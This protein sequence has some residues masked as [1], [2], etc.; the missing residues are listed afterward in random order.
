MAQLTMAGIAPTL[1]RFVAQGP[2]EESRHERARSAVVRLLKSVTPCRRAVPRPR[3]RGTRPGDPLS[4][5][6]GTFVAFVLPLYFGLKTILY[7][8]SLIRTYAV[9]EVTSDLVFFGVLAFLTIAAPRFA[10]LTFCIAYGGFSLVAF[11]YIRRSASTAVVQPPDWSM[12]RFAALAMVATYASANQAYAV[13]LLT[14]VLSTSSAAG[15]S[16]RSSC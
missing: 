11:A 1:M 8:L 10:I 2:T 12:A 16:R 6:L 9:L 14:G 13:L 5:A 3:R 15:Q 4:L 7:G